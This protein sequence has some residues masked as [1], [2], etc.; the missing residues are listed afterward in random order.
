MQRDVLTSAYVGDLLVTSYSQFS[1]NRN[2][3]V[4][5]GKGYSVK[6]TQIEMDMVAEAIMP[7]RA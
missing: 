1:R 6:T 2:F 7:Q 5:I 4:M 3:G